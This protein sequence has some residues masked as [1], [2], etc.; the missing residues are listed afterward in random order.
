MK[1]MS[2]IKRFQSAAPSSAHAN[3]K[4]KP[5]VKVF[6]LKLGPDKDVRFERMNLRELAKRSAVVKLT[7]DKEERSPALQAQIREGFQAY[8]RGDYRPIE[9]FMAELEA[10]LEQQ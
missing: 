6:R 5:E 8:L 10:E 9:E 2:M 4:R 1:Q 7:E 3:E